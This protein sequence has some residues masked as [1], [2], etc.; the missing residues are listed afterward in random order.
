MLPEVGNSSI[1][2]E[3]YNTSAASHRDFSALG[4]NYRSLAENDENVNEINAVVLKSIFQ[5]RCT[6]KPNSFY[7]LESPKPDFINPIKAGSGVV[8][9][10]PKEEFL[11]TYIYNPKF[12]STYQ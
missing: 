1:S 4:N 11:S 3:A 12:I 6:S 5:K 10:L 2:P 8:F 9:V 7:I